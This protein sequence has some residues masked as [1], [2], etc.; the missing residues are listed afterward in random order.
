[1][2]SYE[3]RIFVESE[4]AVGRLGSLIFL[5]SPLLDAQKTG[6]YTIST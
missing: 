3:I 1:M 6:V 5:V 4:A 2:G